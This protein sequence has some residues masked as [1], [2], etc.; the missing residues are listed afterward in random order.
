MDPNQPRFTIEDFPLYGHEHVDRRAGAIL[1][2]EAEVEQ[3]STDTETLVAG[4]ELD[5]RLYGGPAYTVSAVTNPIDVM[6]YGASLSDFSDEALI[7][8][9]TV[10]TDTPQVISNFTNACG[11]YRLKVKSSDAGQHGTGTF[12]G[13]AK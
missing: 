3:L 9:E 1:R 7:A 13:M 6:V 11:F 8:A 12:N 10:D 4:S 2:M 5:C